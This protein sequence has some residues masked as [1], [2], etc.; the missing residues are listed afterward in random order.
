MRDYNRVILMGNL[1]QDPELK[2]TAANKT[3]TN[4]TVATNRSW[5]GPEGQEA[6]EVS[7]IDCEVWGKQAQTIKD[8]FHKG[9]PIFV[10]G[11]LKQETWVNKETQKKQSRLRVVVESFNFIDSK[12][13]EDS[14]PACAGNTSSITDEDFDAL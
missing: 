2:T 14:I 9:R 11:R 1:S 10:E 3:V 6:S 7:F 4:F 12:K 13:S 8:Y 5:I